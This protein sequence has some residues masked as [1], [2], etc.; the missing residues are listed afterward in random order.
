MTKQRGKENS[1]TDIYALSIGKEDSWKGTPL[2]AEEEQLKAEPTTIGANTDAGAAL[3]T[4]SSTPVEL[5]NVKTIENSNKVEDNLTNNK[6]KARKLNKSP[7]PRVCPPTQRE[8]EVFRKSPSP[9]LPIPLAG[10]VA[11]TPS[12]VEALS[13]ISAI[14]SPALVKEVENVVEQDP[15]E[16]VVT[17][18]PSQLSASAAD[19]GGGGGG[20]GNGARKELEDAI[21]R[22]EAHIKVTI[23]F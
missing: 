9:A 15:A 21:Q 22:I 6:E 19:G 23:K 16:T 7:F 17:S 13:P 18:P 1:P 20:G 5:V 4:D 2:D 10:E 11:A 14:V 8:L 3:S 12:S